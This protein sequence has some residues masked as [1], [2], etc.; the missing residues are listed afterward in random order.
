MGRDACR[1]LVEKPEG[2]G[3]LGKPRH[4]WEYNITIHIQEIGLR[5][6]D[7]IDLAYDRK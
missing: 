1:I 2:N 3:P 4:R 5:G 6:M 7:R